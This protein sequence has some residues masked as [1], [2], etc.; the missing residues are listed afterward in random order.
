MV[1]DEFNGRSRGDG[2]THQ[3]DAMLSSMGLMGVFM[4]L[5][6]LYGFVSS[7]ILV[8]DPLI[9]RFRVA[10]PFYQVLLLFSPSIRPGVQNTLHFVLFFIVDKVRWWVRVVIPMERRLPIRGEQVHV[11]H[12]VDLPV[13]W[14]CQLIAD[15]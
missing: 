11:E 15:G 1:R 9:V 14:K 10:L 4:L 12:G 2:G 5:V 13:G 3:G 6:C 8:I 7:H